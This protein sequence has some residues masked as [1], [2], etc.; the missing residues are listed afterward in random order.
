MIFGCTTRPY[1][2]LD[3]DR[4]CAA[5]AAAGFSDVAL[6]Y[7]TSG[8][9]IQIPVTADSS[10]AQIAAV[11]HATVQAG[12]RPSLLLGNGQIELGLRKATSQYLRLID[13]AA[14]LGAHMLLDLGCD[15]AALLDD[16]LAMMQ[17]VLPHAAAANILITL[18]P[19]GGIT[20]KPN[21]LLAIKDI[22][23]HPHFALSFD[24]GNWL[25]YSVGQIKPEDCIDHQLPHCANVIIKDCI[26]REDGPD[27]EI[28]PGSGLVD[29]PHLFQRLATH[30]FAGP[31]FLECVAGH[32]LADINHNV[33]AAYLDMRH[34]QAAAASSSLTTAPC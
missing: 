29:F 17:A 9:Q 34:W 6:Y 30:E 4:A 3:F 18:K 5:I 28:N 33:R 10:S 7:S 23:K 25:Y 22:L 20:S 32:H 14:Q 11:R 27:V 31:I 16:Y 13:N 19:H 2:M 15:D 12:L 24:P 21:E 1:Q 8:E 26:L